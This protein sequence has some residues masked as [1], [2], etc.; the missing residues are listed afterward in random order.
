MIHR[1]SLNGFRLFRL[2]TPSKESIIGILGPNG[3][4]KSTA[5]NILNGTIIPN[6]GEF[7]AEETLWENVIETLPRGEL[8]DF[9]TELNESSV[10]VA[11]KP[12]Y[13]DHIPKAFKGNVGKLLSSVNER[14]L[15]D[16]MVDKFGLG[17]IRK[18][19]RPIIWR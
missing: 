3:M 11:L 19:F 6:L 9:L 1:Y 4:G 10:K 17:H 18:K 2:P 15:Y 8:R 14:G 5:F 12:Q 16:E 7:E 13:V